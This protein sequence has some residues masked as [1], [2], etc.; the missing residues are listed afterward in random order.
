MGTNFVFCWTLDLVYECIYNSYALYEY[1]NVFSYLSDTENV[2]KL[3][4]ANESQYLLIC[5]Q[6][7]EDLQHRIQQSEE[8]P[9]FGIYL[10]LTF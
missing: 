3:S 9:N 6:S 2:S 4:L 10:N 1:L 5:R 7:V 8:K